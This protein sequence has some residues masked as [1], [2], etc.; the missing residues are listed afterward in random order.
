M[1]KQRKRSNLKY[2]TH[3]LNPLRK[4]GGEMQKSPQGRGNLKNYQAQWKKDNY[5]SAREGEN[6]VWMPQKSYGFVWFVSESHNDD[7]FLIYF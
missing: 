6:K 5:N 3:P 4:G 7:S 2:S 1:S